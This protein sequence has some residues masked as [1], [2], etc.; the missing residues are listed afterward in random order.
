MTGLRRINS[1]R[2]DKGKDTAQNTAKIQLGFILQHRAELIQV[3]KKCRVKNWKW[4][5]VRKMQQEMKQGIPF[6]P[7]DMSK[8][9]EIYEEI[10]GL[11]FDMPSYK[12]EFY[13]GHPR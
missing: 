13:K 8:L 6:E 12:K 11:A 2:D 7:D 9:D 10:I 4:N 5:K 3:N 1:G